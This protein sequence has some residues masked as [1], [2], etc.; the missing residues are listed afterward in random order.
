MKMDK[1]KV[2]KFN[3]LQRIAEY[4]YSRGRYV[5]AKEV[6]ATMLTLCREGTL[7]HQRVLSNI[8]D[9]QEYIDIDNSIL[10][11]EMTDPLRE[12]LKNIS[13]EL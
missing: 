7:K 12:T 8:S 6:Y 1:S 9:M 5:K 13:D 2:N 4:F 10:D 3:D 11:A